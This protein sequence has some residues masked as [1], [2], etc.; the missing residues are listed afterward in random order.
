M[1]RGLIFYLCNSANCKCLRTVDILKQNKGKNSNP[2]FRPGAKTLD[3]NAL[4]IC[5]GSNEVLWLWFCQTIQSWR[6]D[7]NAIPSLGFW[8]YSNFRDLRFLS[9]ISGLSFLRL[10]HFNHSWNWWPNPSN[11]NHLP[12]TLCVGHIFLATSNFHQWLQAW[13]MTNTAHCFTRFVNLRTIN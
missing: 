3:G 11:T 7:F 13:Q 6:P 9:R 10:D 2:S 5:W 8:L 4:K 1:P 12:V